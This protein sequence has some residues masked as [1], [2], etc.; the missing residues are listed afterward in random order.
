[1]K[2]WD[3]LAGVRAVIHDQTEAFGERKFLSHD[4]GGE[5]EVAEEGLVGRGGFA[6]AGNRFFR[7]D[8]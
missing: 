8:E 3:G 6:D 2:V 4:A 5:Q 7:D 1:M